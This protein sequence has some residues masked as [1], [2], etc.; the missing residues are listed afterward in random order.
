[1]RTK[2]MSMKNVL[3]LAMGGTISACGTDRLDLKDYQTG[4]YS[5]E[6]LIAHIPELKDVAD[7]KVEQLANVTSTEINMTHWKQL[8]ERIIKAF[9]EENIDGVV[10]THGT[11]TIEETAYFLHLTVPSEKPVVIVGSQRPFSS[12]SSDAQLN[13]LNAFRVAADD[14]SRGKGVIVVEND[15]ISCAR[16]VTKTNTYRIGTFQSG[17]FGYLGFVDPDDTVK[18][19]RSPTRKHTINSQFAH[20]SIDDV[21]EVEIVYSYAGATGHLIRYITNS[22]K[23]KGIVVAGTG[24]GLFS[25]DEEEALYE[26]KEKGLHVVRSA[27]VGNGRVV[28]INKYKDL[29]AIS[30]DNLLPQKARILLMLSLLITDDVADIQHIFD[31][32]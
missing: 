1:M 22:N 26:A 14:E 4:V 7:V 27:H 10:I 31:A 8:R 15:S 19:F 11:N 17:Q 25:Q 9:N 3:L 28:G 23:Y 6:Y 16:E 12:I 13:L 21:P 2:G 24:A 18:Y 20:V 29:K 32:H 5:G 30:A